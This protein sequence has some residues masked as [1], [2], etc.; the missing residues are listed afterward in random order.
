MK[1]RTMIRNNARMMAPWI[2]LAAMLGLSTWLPSRVELSSELEARKAEVAEAMQSVPLFIADWVGEEEVVPPSA[3]RLLRPNAIFSRLYVDLS[4]GRQSASSMHVI[5][6]HCND[7]RDMIGHYPPICY[8]SAG[9][10]ETESEEGDNAA[11]EFAE[12]RVPARTYHFRRMSERGAETAIRIFNVFI[13]PD[14]SV[15]QDIGEINKQSERLAVSA[16]GV[17]QLQIIS[18]AGMSRRE[19]VESASELLGG[20]T[21]MFEA[22]RLHQGAASET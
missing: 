4:P 18:S 8:P 11:L 7:A 10:V 12:Y 5:V 3:Q 6:V 15:T 1:R 19:A 21:G 9:W 14:G 2:S 20:M 13:L 16:Q 22:L 17:A